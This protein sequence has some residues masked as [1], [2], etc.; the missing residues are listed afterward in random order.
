M[1]QNVRPYECP[2]IALAMLSKLETQS[3]CKSCRLGPRSPE[4]LTHSIADKMEDAEILGEGRARRRF[5]G[6]A[7]VYEHSY[8]VE[9]AQSA[10]QRQPWTDHGAHCGPLSL[11]VMSP[12]L[13]PYPV[14]PQRLFN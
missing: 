12:A 9:L 14:P 1:Y 2:Q 3:E 13:S 7:A 10:R 4:K 11:P 6:D 5:A 8:A